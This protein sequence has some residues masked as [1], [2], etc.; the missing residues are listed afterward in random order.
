[1]NYKVEK[2]KI[3]T[4]KYRAQFSNYSILCLST[5]T[6]PFR[7]TLINLDDNHVSTECQVQLKSHSNPQVE[8]IIF[9]TDD[10]GMIYAWTSDA[11]KNQLL[12]GNDELQSLCLVYHCPPVV[13]EHCK[14]DNTHSAVFS[15][16]RF[17]FL[18]YHAPSIGD[19]SSAISSSSSSNTSS[20]V[21][22]GK[23]RGTF[24]QFVFLTQ[25]THTCQLSRCFGDESNLLCRSTPN[26]Q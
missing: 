1:M 2:H 21:G 10:F 4:F 16:G 13:M 24:Y 14:S 3:K 5:K 19:F 20:A 22:E 23:E 6:G 18:L 11:V 7:N 8:E 17:C 26:I 12:D 15:P 25:Q 9:M